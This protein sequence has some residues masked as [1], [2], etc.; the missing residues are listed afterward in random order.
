M[1]NES[2]IQG[3]ES[4]N[5]TTTET[6]TEETHTDE[7]SQDSTDVEH[8][9]VKETSEAK[10]ARLR[11]QL[12][13][14]EKKAGIVEKPVKQTKSGELD[15]SHKAFLVANG[16]KGGDEMA[17]VSEI[18]AN[19]GK[20][21]DDVIESKYF[22]AELKELRDVKSTDNAVVSGSKRSSQSTRDTVEYWIGKGEL[23]PKEQRELRQKVVNARYTAEK[24]K[25]VF[26]NS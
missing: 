17:L 26:Y 2:D 23:P 22:K 1:A 20:S 15:Y 18:M 11:R 3:V 7:S 6:T 13:R 19:T 10:I 8:T 9:E 25:N 12:S 16:I 4:Q 21:L 5:T 24:S 14:E